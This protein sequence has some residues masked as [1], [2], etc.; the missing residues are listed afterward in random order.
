MIAADSLDQTSF[1]STTPIS[2]LNGLF[3][4]A[5]AKKNARGIRED[6]HGYEQMIKRDRRRQRK[7][8]MQL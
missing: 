3:Y 6:Q 1:R 4:Q 8:E 7:V 2:N 5:N